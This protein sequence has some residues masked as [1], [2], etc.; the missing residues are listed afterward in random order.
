MNAHASEARAV[1][2]E[3]TAPALW[4]ASEK[5]LVVPADEQLRLVRLDA[6]SAGTLQ[7]LR[8]MVAAWEAVAEKCALAFHE[9]VRLAVFRLEVEREGARVFACRSNR[10]RHA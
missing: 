4:A 1:G 9:L 3:V 6:K 7:G 10:V 2:V 8:Q 5:G